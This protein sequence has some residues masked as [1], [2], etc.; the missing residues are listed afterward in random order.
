MPETLALFSSSRRDGNTGRLMDCIAQKLEIEVIDLGTFRIAP[1][2]YNHSNRHDDFEPLMERLLAHEQ[3]ILASPVYWYSVTPQMKAFL[4]RITDFLDLPDLLPKG[5]RLRGKRAFIVC[6][7]ASEH[8][9]AAFTG[10]LSETFDYLGMD[11]AGMLHV[12]CAD[13]YSPLLH[14]AA[15]RDFARLV[16]GAG[17][18]ANRPSH[19]PQPRPGRCPALISR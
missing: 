13:G 2:D 11:L 6:T 14:D 17:A 18:A 7:S 9:S 8:P 19:S 12:N 10:A 1:Y 5:R 3:I 15:A 16:A 4:D